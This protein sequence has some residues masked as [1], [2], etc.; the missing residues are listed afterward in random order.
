MFILE[1]TRGYR[2]TFA[3]TVRDADGNLVDL[4]S[5]TLPFIVQEAYPD[6]DPAE[7]VKETGTG[8]THADNQSGAGKGKATLELLVA[9]TSALPDVAFA[10]YPAQLTL[11]QVADQP[12]VI[13]TGY[14]QVKRTV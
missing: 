4:D 9:D 7:I 6:A 10:A 12:E 8:I 5:K 14:L 11:E 13:D 3:L 1:L 2:K